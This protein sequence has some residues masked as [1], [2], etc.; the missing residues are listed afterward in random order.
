MTE[1]DTDQVMQIWLATNIQTHDFVPE[2]Y[3]RSQFDEVKKMLPVS[4]VYVCEES[5]EIIGFVG[6]VETY[7][8]G[9]FVSSCFQSHGIGKR[10]LDYAKALKPELYLHVY[11]KNLNAIRFYQREGFVIESEEVDEDTGEAEFLMRICAFG[12]SDFDE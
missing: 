4:E 7:I 9:I 5:K 11:Q 2:T 6:L 3:W 1:T 8:A 10:L 12:S